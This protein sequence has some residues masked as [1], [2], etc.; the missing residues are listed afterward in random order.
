[1]NREIILFLHCMPLKCLNYVMT[2]Y[3]RAIKMIK[4]NFEKMKKVKSIKSLVYLA[5]LI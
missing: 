2:K 4:A 1:M 3:T 5:I